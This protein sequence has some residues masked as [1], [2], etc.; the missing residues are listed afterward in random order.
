[1]TTLFLSYAQENADCALHIRK[2]LEQ[3][4]YTVWREPGYPD[5]QSASYPR[6]IEHAIIACAAQ[7][8][9]WS[10]SAAQNAE[11]ECQ[12]FFAQDIKKPFFPILLDSTG[13]PATLV[14]A[15]PPISP[16]SCSAA[17]SSLMT[18]PGFPPPHSADPL[19]TLYEQAAHEFVRERK[20]ALDHAA[21]MLQRHEH[22]EELLALLA[23]LAKHDPLMGVRDRAQEIL[24]AQIQKA[25]SSLP[26]SGNASDIFG[27]RCKNGHISYF[28][29]RI[30]CTAY[31]DVLR[32]L[33][34]SAKKPLD[35]LWL[36]CSICGV[37]VVAYVDC[38]NY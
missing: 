22:R 28:A 1:M 20:A 15:S 23:Y 5:P 8:L 34:P 4:G 21:E 2:E 32:V 24:D 27:V 12:I 11:V 13:L 14:A 38:E 9:L 18:S 6:L 19:I 36:K 29:K 10:A 30:V 17:V 26:P 7:V 37:D 16:S 33:K 3:R 25:P 35:E 31:K